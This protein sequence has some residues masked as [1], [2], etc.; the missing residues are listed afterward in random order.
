MLTGMYEPTSGDA[1]VGGSSIKKNM[2]KVQEQIGYCPQFDLV[3][4]DL[5]VEEHLY[6]YSRLKNVQSDRCKEVSRF[7]LTIRT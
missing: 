2:E 3:W 1:W 6:F 4:N 7:L 5:T